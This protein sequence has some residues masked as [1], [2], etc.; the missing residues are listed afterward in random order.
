MQSIFGGT[1]IEQIE[2]S[3]FGCSFDEIDIAYG[4]GDCDIQGVDMKLVDLEGFIAFIPGPG[5]GQPV[6]KIFMRHTTGD[7]S[8]A[9][10]LSRGKVVQHDIFI[11]QSLGLLYRKNQRRAEAG[12]GGC[13]VLR[14]HD[15]D[16]KAGR[17]ACFLVE[18]GLYAILILQ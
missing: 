12:A 1:K 13:L 3:L 16:G 2:Q 18:F 9:L 6:L 17:V 7:F 14:V 10:L 8:K 15:N 11:L 4:A 5:V